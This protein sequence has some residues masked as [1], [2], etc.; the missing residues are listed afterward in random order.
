MLPTAVNRKNHNPGNPMR[1]GDVIR[2]ALNIVELMDA[3]SDALMSSF[4]QTIDDPLVQAKATSR[5]RGRRRTHIHRKPRR[6]RTRRHGHPQNSHRA[7]HRQVALQNLD[8]I[9]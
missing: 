4:K 5:I 2:H 6:H 8:A 9:Q 7:E 1:K 3:V